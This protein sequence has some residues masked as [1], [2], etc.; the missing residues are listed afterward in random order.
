MDFVSSSSSVPFVSLDVVPVLDWYI[1]QDEDD[2]DEC[3]EEKKRMRGRKR[4]ND[5]GVM[6]VC[7]CR[8]CLGGKFVNKKLRTQNL[9][10]SDP[11]ERVSIV[12]STQDQE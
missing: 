7:E 8:V 4:W 9:W 5:G 3:A 1:W 2:V 12:I 10:R 11:R 6:V